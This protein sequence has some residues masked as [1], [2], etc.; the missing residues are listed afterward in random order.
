MSKSF[1]KYQSIILYG[2][3]VLAFLLLLMIATVGQEAP[4]EKNLFT[5]DGGGGVAWYAVFILVGIIIAALFS[6]FEFKH[7]GVDENILYDGLLFSVPIAIVGARLW[8]VIFNLGDYS[9]IWE[10]FE[11]W[12]GGLGIHGAIIVTFIFLIFFTK[13]KKISYWWLLDVVAPGFLIGQTMGRWGNFMNQELY[14]P[15]IDNLNWLPPVI[16]DQMFIG[17]EYRHPTFLYES[18]FNLAGLILVLI[19][20]R[21]KVFKLGDIVSLYLVWYGIARIPAELL[22]LQSGVDEPLMIGGVSVSIAT[23]ILFIVGGLA[24]FI[25]KRIFA[26]DLPYY[27]TYGKH[28]VLFDLDGTLL[29]TKDLIFKN[30]TL[31][32]KKYF[33]N[34]TLTEKELKAFVGPT[35]EESFSWYEKNPAKIAQMIETYREFNRLHHADG[36]PAFPHIL[37]TFRTLKENDY[38]I[39][40][41]SS[42]KREFVE[43]GLAQ[44]ELLGYVDVVI[45]S[46]DVL[47][48][49]PDPTALLKALEAINVPVENAWYVGDHENDIKAAT[50]AKMKSIGVSYSIHYEALLAAKPDYVVDDLEKI[51]EIV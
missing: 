12:R 10:M 32:F 17:G 23:S 36:V 42:K 18:L 43:L 38:M 26:K 6:Y 45:G 46:D 22:R 30:V 21:K 28:A 25:G 19:L 1:K 47:V 44:H 34:K 33:P 29:D 20:R 41:V 31:T 39:G 4:Y 7:Y 48:H 40:V 11:I 24:V 16:R 8:F 35:L 2:G 3:A 49:K 37:E 14:G 15:V 51:L 5:F 13:W 50:N 27:N 9:N